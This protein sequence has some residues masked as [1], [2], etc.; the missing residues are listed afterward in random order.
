VCYLFSF[1][2][3]VCCFIFVWCLVMSVHP[4]RYDPYRDDK[5]VI[6]D[7]GF[8]VG[9]KMRS[10]R[11][12]KS[13][14]VSDIVAYPTYGAEEYKYKDTTLDYLDAPT[15]SHSTLLNGLTKGTESYNR[16]GRKITCRCLE[17]SYYCRPRAE[18]T[19]LNAT[20]GAEITI[21]VRIMVV[22]DKQ[23]NGAIVPELKM[24]SGS[25]YSPGS[26]LTTM[27]ENRVVV[28]Y[29]K[30]HVCAGKRCMMPYP[31]NYVSTIWDFELVKDRVCI[32]LNLPTMYNENNGGNIGD[33]TTGS[34]Y[35]ITAFNYRVDPLEG[36]PSA[37]IENATIGYA[38]LSYTDN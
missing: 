20:P 37:L 33:I 15:S 13:P 3:E 11:I 4:A 14:D 9:G 22:Y 7:Q 26:A 29:D 31:P 16:I 1:G 27:Y 25:A 6:C 8:G 30:W 12:R 36:Q 35:F 38:K 32:D 19:S 28:L 23:S 5:Q 2:V 17:L 24:S 10:T 21:S 18:W 34:L